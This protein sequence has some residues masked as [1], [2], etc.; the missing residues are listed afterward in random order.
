[1]HD[2]SDYLLD[3]RANWDERAAVHAASEDYH[4]QK[5]VTDPTYISHVVRFDRQRLGDIRGLQR[6][7]RRRARWPIAQRPM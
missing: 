1:M 4:V 2:Y 3:N 7:S 6:L 5:F